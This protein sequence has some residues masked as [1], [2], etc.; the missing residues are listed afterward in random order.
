MWR[1][2]RLGFGA[3]C[4]IAALIELVGSSRCAFAQAAP[5]PQVAAPAPR[6]Q[7]VAPAQPVVPA[8]PRKPLP[9]SQAVSMKTRDGVQLAG[10][11][12]PSPLD[13]EVQKDAAVVILLH[14]FKGSRGDFNDLAL[15]LQASGCAVLCPDLRGHGESTR[16]SMPDGSERKIESAMLSRQDL[17]AMVQY[18]VEACKS[19]LFEKHQ[20]KE[21]NI[22]KL[23]LVGAEMGGAVATNW[24]AWDWHW[25]ALATGKQGQDVKAVVLLSPVWV[26][27]G[28]PISQA[29]GD[30]DL[31]SKLSWLIVVGNQEA[32]ELSEAKRL[33]Q[34]IER[35]FPTDAAKAAIGL[36]PIE[37]SLQGTKMLATR[38]T[39][40]QIVKFI[41]T[42][43]AKKSYAWA[44]R[45]SP[46]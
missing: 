4:T 24:A 22:E 40:A 10:T 27:K 5:R 13:K 1:S 44:D 3:I 14:A 12:F 15:Q 42:Q 32:R 17:E 45:K 37:T 46:I 29:V 9:K 30:R 41:D 18:D 20:A 6:A 31:V 16:R 25:P 34:S 7:P 2:L 26:F 43:V 19:F 36:L 28:L 11:F 38:G 33:F 21:L 23:A 35:F 39:N 8:Q